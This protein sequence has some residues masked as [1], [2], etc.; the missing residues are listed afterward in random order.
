MKNKSPIYIAIASLLVIIVLFFIFKS[1]SS[2]KLTKNKISTTKKES[3]LEYAQK[4]MKEQKGEKVKVVTEKIEKNKPVEVEFMMHDYANVSKSSH[5]LE[6]IKKSLK[7]L[8]GK[9]Y[10]EVLKTGKTDQLS[11]ISRAGE[12]REYYYII[13]KFKGDKNNPTGNT[14]HPSNLMETG[15][16]PAP[17]FVWVDGDRTH[18]S[19]SLDAKYVL[20]MEGYPKPPFIINLTTP[21]WLTLAAVW[22]VNKESNPTIA[23]KYV[24]PKGNIHLLKL[25]R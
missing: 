15:W 13:Y 9:A 18:Y 1:K 2:T 12:G 7:P 11:S 16:D 20:K 23:L 6:G 22:K 5:S 17:Q 19:R 3:V 21:T 8:K 4:T 14:V 24:D 25:V 10:F